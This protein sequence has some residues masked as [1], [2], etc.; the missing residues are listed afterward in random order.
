MAAASGTA[1]ADVTAESK[2]EA[3]KH[4]DRAM[5]LNEDG[6]VAAAIIELKRCYEIAPHHTVLYNLGQAYI[7]LGKPV[8]AVDALQRYLEEGDKAIHPARRAAVEREIARQKTRIALLV[9]RALPAGAMVSV[10]GDDVGKTPLANP[11]R[12][13]VGRHVVSATAAG[14]EPGEASFF[15]R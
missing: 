9:I 10:D 12:V 5:G 4:Y 3:K 11:V 2:A 6:Q 14:Y 13:G 15:I 7:S 1:R 8:E